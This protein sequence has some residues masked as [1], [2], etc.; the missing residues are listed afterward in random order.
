MMMRR[1]SSN[2]GEISGQIKELRAIREVS[3]WPWALAVLALAALLFFLRLG[4]RALWGPEGR[5][6]E[7]AREMLLSGNYFWPT[8]NGVVY[9]DKPLLSYWLVVGTAH[10]TGDLNET[11]AR[12]PS[13]VAGIVGVALLMHLVRRLYDLRMAILAGFILATSY[14]Y[15]FFLRLASADIE[16]VAGVVA[17]LTLFVHY[18]SRQNGWWVVALWLIMAVT[19]LTKGL[20]GFLLPLLVIGLYSF[21]AEGWRKMLKE[22]LRSSSVRKL[23]WL[24]TYHSWFFNWRTLLAVTVAG[25]VYSLPFAVSYMQMRSNI[26]VYKVIHENL[27]RFLHPFDHQEPV[28]LYVYAIFVLMA[29]WS[30]F[31]P[32]ALVQIYSKPRDKSDRFVLVYFWTTLLFFTL[33]G[34]RRDYYLLPIV[35]AGA[36]L[37]ARLFAK[38][39]ETQ[40]NLTPKLMSFAYI[41]TAILLVIIGVVAL[42]PPAIRPGMLSDLPVLPG[43]T[44]FAVLWV[45]M[46][47]TAVYALLDLRPERMLLSYSAI[48]YLGLLFLFGFG[49]PE[50]GRYRGEKSFAQTVRAELEDDVERLVLYKIW[51]PGLLFYLS[52]RGPVRVFSDESS[53]VQFVETNP[54]TWVISRERDITTIP[55]YGSVVVREQGFRWTEPQRPQNNYIL[56]R[57]ATPGNTNG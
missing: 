32:A 9:Y 13:A 42:L 5:W 40:D 47:I 38:Q 33:S 30:A 15:V 44:I 1:Y 48:A 36:I 41:V 2:S 25:T 16:T 20:I 43:H 34:S 29:P 6:A 31:L 39:R 50:A 24:T 17:A 21:F 57:P 7:I 3:L 18:E 19:S 4:D 12:L 56:F 28:Y 14:S 11:A 26:G 35:P 49:L 51:G 55:L 53:L 10:L 37:I 52:A 46:L 23:N 45:V 54:D 22:V 27:I 8:I